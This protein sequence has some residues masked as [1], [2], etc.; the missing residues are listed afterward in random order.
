LSREAIRTIPPPVDGGALI[1]EGENEG[2]SAQ[3]SRNH[4]QFR[5][6]YM[7]SAAVVRGA[8]RVIEA[9]VIVAREHPNAK[10]IMLVRPDRPIFRAHAQ[11]LIKRARLSGFEQK[12]SIVDDYLA[13]TEVRRMISGCD[14]VVLPFRLV[15]S[16]MPISVVEAMAMGKPVIS[17]EVDGIA[18]LLAPNRGFTLRHPTTSDLA[19]RMEALL[20]NPDSA[21]EVGKAAR[22]FVLAELFNRG[23]AKALSEIVESFAGE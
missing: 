2:A 3:G 14:V 12:I 6:L 5:F 16:D 15:P 9:F 21:L 8:E 23:C 7:G 1:A 20:E 10:L 13:P 18:E 11:H 19:A 22:V 17:T 4:G